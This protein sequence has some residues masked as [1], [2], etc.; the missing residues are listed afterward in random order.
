MEM[1]RS[2]YDALPVA[3][4]GLIFSLAAVEVTAHGPIVQA[5]GG[6]WYRL[7][8]KLQGAARTAAPFQGRVTGRL[9]QLLAG[10]AKGERSAGARAP[11]P[12]RL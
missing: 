1:D 2:A 7:A 8:P 5:A 3:R 6:T 10:M 12:T 9:G 11:L 4:G